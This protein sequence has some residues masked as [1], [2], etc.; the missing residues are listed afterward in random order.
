ME[1]Q[2]AM[3]QI[4]EIHAQLSKSEVFRGYRAWPIATTGATAIA[5]AAVQATLMPA[6]GPVAFTRFWLV[7]AACC[8]TLCALDI[9][10]GFRR[11]RSASERRRS[12]VA[13]GQFLPAFAVGGVITVCLLGSDGAATHLLPGIWCLVYAL[14]IFSSRLHLPRAIGW[15]ALWFVLAG[16]FLLWRP[17]GTPSPWSM[18]LSFGIGQLAVAWVLF[19]NL[20]RRNGNGCQEKA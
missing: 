12:L 16:A 2:K 20:E 10:A 9:A 6:D 7:V 4:S 13:M 14:G 18:G 5:A 1:L 17:G 15:T 3:S 11:E 8:V 19:T